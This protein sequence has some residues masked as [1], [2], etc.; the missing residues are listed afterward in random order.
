[1]IVMDLE[2]NGGVGDGIALDEILQI[3]AVKYDRENRVIVD[4]FNRFIHP[5]VHSSFSAGAKMLPQLVCSI[6]SDIT[7]EQAYNDFVKWTGEDAVFASWGGEDWRVL[8]KNAEYYSLPIKEDMRMLDIQSAF[9]FTMGTGAVALHKAVDFCHIPDCFDYHDA[10]MDAM[11]TALVS[12][13]VGDEIPERQLNLPKGVK[14]PPIKYD[15]PK[16]KHSQYL[17]SRSEVLNSDDM[18]LVE[19]PVCGARHGISE[20]CS[21]DRRRYYGVFH[22]KGHGRFICRLTVSQKDKLFRGCLAIPQLTPKE[23]KCFQDAQRAKHYLC[24]AT[25]NLIAQ[26][27][28]ERIMKRKAAENSA[29]TPAK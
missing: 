8:N 10:L 3:G 25:A 26:K 24:N 9:G 5:S 19:C 14:A 4:S 11:Y 29:D 7:F 1:M 23:L 16:L 13:Y 22:C 21:N 17:K 15:P 2:W 18:R 6:E 12:E 27:R 28:K 20:W